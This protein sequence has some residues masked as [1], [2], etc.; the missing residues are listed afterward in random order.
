MIAKKDILDAV[1]RLIVSLGR[2]WTVYRDSLPEQFDRP[3]YYIS[4]GQRSSKPATRWTCEIEQPVQILCIGALNA[5]G[6]ADI[7]ALSQ[8]SDEVAA[9]LASGFLRVGTRALHIQG[10]TEKR[11]ADDGEEVT[12]TLSYFDEVPEEGDT[13]PPA[14]QI[15]TTTTIEEG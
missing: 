9:V 7:D 2:D 4:L 1:N 12:F 5:D 10:Q 3:S 6:D 11:A 13:Q 15:H 14:E 8:M